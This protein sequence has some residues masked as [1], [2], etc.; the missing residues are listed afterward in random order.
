M[1]ADNLDMRLINPIPID[2]LLNFRDTLSI[3]RVG[4]LPDE[5]RKDMHIFQGLLYDYESNFIIS[6]LEDYFY[7]DWLKELKK[8][9]KKHP[10]PKWHRYAELE[11]FAIDSLSMYDYIEPIQYYQVGPRYRAKD[12]PDEKLD[13]I[14]FIHRHPYE[15]NEEYG[16]Y[17]KRYLKWKK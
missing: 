15:S 1:K 2:E 17:L 8:I 14:Y 3:A 16:K 5:D 4:A 13:Q 10:N 9:E 7:H 6:Y 11:E 12:I